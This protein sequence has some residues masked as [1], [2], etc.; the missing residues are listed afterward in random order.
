MESEG[1]GCLNHAIIITALYL[2]T[3]YTCNNLKKNYQE[4][5]QKE[6]SKSNVQIY[7]E[8]SL[9]D[10]LKENESLI[11]ID[12]KKYGKECEF[13]IPTSEYFKYKIMDHRG[14]DQDTV[15]YQKWVTYDD[16]TIKNIAAKLTKNLK[17]PEKKAQ[18]LLDFVHS[19]IY[20]KSIEEKRDYIK[21]P[22][23]TIIEHG[24][25]CEDLSILGAALMKS[26]GIDVALLMPDT[27]K[28]NH[29]AFAVNGDF[30]G[31]CV[32][33]NDKKFFYAESTT[34]ANWKI[35]EM[36]EEY[37]GKKSRFYPIK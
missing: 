29:I 30:E 22:L 35:G 15:A 6:N 37:D 26:V 25:D 11:I 14:L 24:G 16:S 7:V 33:Y 36:P 31:Y 13:K 20:D 23:E 2:G 8:K 34:S 3:Q 19:H 27:S 4:K 10:K 1:K 9:E 12:A 5:I 18:R 28:L 21:Y 17:S 32:K